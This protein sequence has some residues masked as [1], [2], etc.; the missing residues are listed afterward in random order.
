MYDMVS[1][2]AYPKKNKCVGRLRWVLFAF[3][4]LGCYGA[5]ELGNYYAGRM[6]IYKVI[7]FKENP[8]KYNFWLNLVFRNDKWLAISQISCAIVSTTCVLITIRR[9]YH[10][11]L[12]KFEHKLN[13]KNFDLNY[14][15]ISCNLIFLSI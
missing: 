9:V 11:T 13:L 10:M 14:G 15:M 4:I 6:I 2:T 8:T 12:N 7:P 1:D 3:V 5:M